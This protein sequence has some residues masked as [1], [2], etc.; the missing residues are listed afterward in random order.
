M[1][2]K[3]ISTPPLVIFISVVEEDLDLAL[4]TIKQLQ[5]KSKRIATIAVFTEWGVQAAMR[6]QLD[7][8]RRIKFLESQDA[9]YLWQRLERNFPGCD[10]I[11]VTPGLSLPMYWDNQLQQTA[12]E[13][14]DIATVSA[15]VNGSQLFA[16]FAD[17]E[18]EKQA[19]ENLELVNAILP[20]LKI[21]KTYQVPVFSSAVVFFKGRIL[22]DL[23][24]KC[25]QSNKCSDQV[26]ATAIYNNGWINVISG[27]V[28]VHSRHRR[29]QIRLMQID[30]E[31]AAQLIHAAHPASVLRHLTGDMYA[32]R[33]H[34]ASD[35]RPTQLH[36]M[37]SWGGGL[38]QWVKDFC[39]GDQDRRN[40]VLKSIGDLDAFG[41][42]LA[43]YEHPDAD[44]PIAY[45]DL[46]T[47][48]QA[49]D[50]KNLEYREILNSIVELFGI[51]VI[52]VS[53]L[54]GHTLDVLDMNVRTGYIYHDYLPF[55]PAINIYYQGVCQDCDANKLTNC[56][57]ENEHNRF[58]KNQTAMHWLPIRDQFADTVLANDIQLVIPSPKVKKHVIELQPRL[59][60]ARFNV[61]G[62][63]SRIAKINT[64]EVNE[65]NQHAAFK[66]VIL[67]ELTPHKGMALL[68]GILDSLP[69]NVHLTLLGCG[70]YCGQFKANPQIHIVEKYEH[71]QLPQLLAQLDADLGLLLSI[72]PET[73]SYTLSELMAFAIPTMATCLGAFQDRINDGE[74]GFL[75]APDADSLL[76]KLKALMADRSQL[77]AVKASLLKAK[78]K[79]LS[80]MVADYHHLI[81]QP[82][83]NS[84][85]VYCV[86][87]DNQAQR[88]Q[89]GM[90]FP[91]NDM[92]AAIN[93][94][95]RF[96][97]AKIEQ[98]RK[99]N[100]WTRSLALFIVDIWLWLPRSALRL[101]SFI[102]Q[103]SG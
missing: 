88:N 68:A 13:S 59:R 5:N 65:H 71:E 94:F 24:S 60:D 52:W 35:W 56:F 91:N 4:D 17:A 90:F 99:L 47:P 16:L 39:D 12:Y 14:T 40:L 36:I 9:E 19:D 80:A 49:I 26:L 100:N 20:R 87:E 70:A 54:I 58:F 23:F 22:A 79:D 101:Y 92:G 81:E 89:P 82:L 30:S 31:P 41:K 27:N 96:F 25:G 10:F 75:F 6:T 93:E 67:G 86:G 2:T 42:R 72:W 85:A 84:W 1:Y 43:L 51:D 53:S 103:K 74:N 97:R 77:A 3:D 21:K 15:L 46:G 32:R 95:G 44:E 61:I 102:V 45:W 64:K 11:R 48:I 98:A 55:C 66:V 37:H 62:H 33:F 18:Q 73:F 76:A 50:L 78:G 69:E 34:I 28:Y 8:D 57:N 63:G 83:Y 38:H 7:D 29:T